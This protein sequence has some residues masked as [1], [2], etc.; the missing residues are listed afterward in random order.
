MLNIPPPSPPDEQDDPD[1]LELDFDPSSDDEG[2]SND[3]GQGR[4]E[5]EDDVLVPQSI[6]TSHSPL[7]LIPDTFSLDL[8]PEH[9]S[10]RSSSSRRAS[11]NSVRE[12]VECASISPDLNLQIIPLKKTLEHAELSVQNNNNSRDDSI[13]AKETVE[14]P[15]TSCD[16]SSSSSRFPDQSNP[17]SMVTVVRS[18]PLTSPVDDITVLNMPRS[19]SLNNNISTCLASEKSTTEDDTMLLCGNRLLLR[20]A[21]L[22]RTEHS[23]LSDALVK[24]SVKSDNGSSPLSC[25]RAM[26]WSEKEAY[27]NQ[28]NQLGVSACGA[29][30]LMNVLLGLNIDVEANEV[31]SA[32]DTRLRRDNNELPDYLLSRSLAGC[33]HVDLLEGAKRI[34]R[35]RVVGRFFPMH[36]RRVNLCSW[37]ATWISRGCVPVATLNIQ[38]AAIG[39]GGVIADAWHHQMLWG[40]AGNEVFLTNPLEVLTEEYLSPQLDS[41]SE[42]LI[43]RE[44]VIG[45]FCENTDLS[46]LAA[47]GRSVFDERWSD[48]NV[49]GQTVNILREN[50]SLVQEVENKTVSSHLRI[51]ASYSSG[52]TLFCDATKLDV[53][54]LLN[55]AADLP[56]RDEAS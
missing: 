13:K 28:V 40:V 26:I 20:E 47:D 51:P 55:S 39:P 25:P 50:N 14:T 16:F 46:P 10:P 31:C 45:R 4:E 36:C 2:S 43:R 44:D 11:Q 56:F 8:P 53:L 17:P 7:R 27:R 15:C 42:L 18:V 24:L 37:L 33:T 30:S 21:L 3:S 12:N 49:L 1:F 6:I 48:C 19:K 38:R 5:M 34:S 52:V 35:G 22:F 9:I 54:S 32:V 29:T 41:P 23:E